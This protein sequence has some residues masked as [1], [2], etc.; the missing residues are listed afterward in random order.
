MSNVEKGGNNI[1]NLS[2]FSIKRSGKEAFIFYL[3]Y[4]VL[5]FLIAFLVGATIGLVYPEFTDYMAAV[6]GR[7]IAT[8]Y[9]III[10][11]A[12]YIK[13][14]MDSFKYLIIGI[15]AA[16][17]TLFIGFIITLILPAYLTTKD[18]QLEVENESGKN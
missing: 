5:G 3:A 15:I 2:N 13:K 1:K 7:L 10:Y 6:L 18:N 9:F 4:L 11:F 16:I 17:I 8:I 12:I 14:G